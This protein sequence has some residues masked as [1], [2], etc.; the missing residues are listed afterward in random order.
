MALHQ[1]L[2]E[3][4]NQDYELL[5]QLE[6]KLRYEDDPR[7]KRKWE[8]DIRNVKQQISDR[9]AELD[10]LKKD[11][12]LS[13]AQQKTQPTTHPQQSQEPGNPSPIFDRK[14]RAITKNLKQITEKLKNKTTL[15]YSK[16]NTRKHCGNSFVFH[17]DE[18]YAYLLTCI[19]VINEVG[20]VD[21]IRVNKGSAILIAPTETELSTSKG[22]YNLAVLKLEGDLL[23]L[24]KQDFGL[25][26]NASE[27]SEVFINFYFQKGD[28]KILKTIPAILDESTPIYHEDGTIID[29]WEFTLKKVGEV[30]LQPDSIGSPV[31]DKNDQVIG[32]V[33][34]CENEKQGVAT[35]TKGILYFCQKIPGLCEILGA[36]GFC[37]KEYCPGN[38]ERLRQEKREADLKTEQLTERINPK[39]EERLNNAEPQLKKALYWWLSNQ[40]DLAKQAVT[41]AQAN[42][43]DLEKIISKL[44]DLELKSK[45]ISNFQ[46]EIDQHL[47][48]IFF[49]LLTG[50]LRYLDELLP[51]SLPISAYETALLYIQQ[52]V[53]KH[54]DVATGEIVTKVKA[55]V[56]HLLQVLP[57]QR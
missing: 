51:P 55:Y 44:S 48:L 16:D 7:K 19:R 45:T 12:E 40:A 5:K 49:S 26:K 36:T 10:T 23:K 34:K 38:I 4:L 13:I 11:S 33:S 37:H 20:G 47:E 57:T 3:Q 24:G 30:F 14:K 27:G 56:K 17:H 28:R 29:A 1:H 25:S 53:H 9:E 15:I 39:V 2:E 52:E 8:G 6:D 22:D 43:P 32:I 35:S 41:Y 18:R 42:S 21:N 46:F 54:M 31:I 50:D